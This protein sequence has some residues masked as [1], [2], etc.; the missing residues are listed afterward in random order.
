MKNDE[1]EADDKISAF[2]EAASKADTAIG[3]AQQFLT[4]LSK[5]AQHDLLEVVFGLSSERSK[6]QQVLDKLSKSDQDALLKAL[7]EVNSEL[8]KAQQGLIK[9]G[10][11][12]QGCLKLWLEREGLVERYVERFC[13]AKTLR[14]RMYSLAQIFEHQSL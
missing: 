10:K 1:I 14:T 6:A 3:T 13:K 4:K 12:D 9:A 11:S 5:S 8:C 2:C 7:F